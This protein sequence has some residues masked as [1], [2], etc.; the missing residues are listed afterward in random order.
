[1]SRSPGGA[2]AA[3]APNSHTRTKIFPRED[4]FCAC[5]VCARRVGPRHSR[6]KSRAARKHG[7][8]QFPGVPGPFGC[9]CGH[10]RGGDGAAGISGRRQL[11]EG[12]LVGPRGHREPQVAGRKQAGPSRRLHAEPQ[13]QGE[14]PRSRC[15]CRA[16]ALTSP[17]GQ[18]RSPRFP[19]RSFSQFSLRSP[20]CGEPFSLSLRCPGPRE[21]A[22]AQARPAPP[23]QPSRGDRPPG[24][25]H[26]CP[27][28]SSRGR[29]SALS[30]T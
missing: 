1:M 20:D 23:N 8:S 4:G 11:R 15:R 13:G 10:D 2:L 25:S 22:P 26:T 21:P 7:G 27:T 12:E 28:P 3:D 5:V 16:Q 14:G 6:E 30:H 24:V 19:A 9:E 18:G 29:D 17:S